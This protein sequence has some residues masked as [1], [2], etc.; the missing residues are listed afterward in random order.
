MLHPALP[1]HPGHSLW[2]RDFLGSTGLFGVV[3]KP[4]T[5]ERVSAMID[6]MELFGLGFSW[7]GYESLMVPSSLTTARTATKWDAAGPTV[8]IHA[9]LEDPQDLTEDLARG[10]DRLRGN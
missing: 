5:D 3:L 1:D 9:G 6:G 8:R 7:G 2:K 4:T 10:L